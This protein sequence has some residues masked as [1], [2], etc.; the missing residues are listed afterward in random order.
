MD[1]RRVCLCAE[2]SEIFFY[3]EHDMHMFLL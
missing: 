3:L 1:M 2:K